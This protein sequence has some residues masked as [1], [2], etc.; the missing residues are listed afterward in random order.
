[1]GNHGLQRLAEELA[2]RP[3]SSL[4]AAHHADL[5][6]KQAGALI[7]LLLGDE[8]KPREGKKKKSDLS[9]KETVMTV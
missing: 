8:F 3:P 5:S 4:S 1:M 2:R 6:V 9:I 7:Q